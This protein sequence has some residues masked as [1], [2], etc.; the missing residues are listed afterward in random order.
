MF[1]VLI[2]LDPLEQVVALAPNVPALYELHFGV[3]MAGAVLSPLN[4][5]LDAPTLA[6]LLKQL[7]PK[8]M[9]V[10]YQFTHILFNTM[11]LIEL[12]PHLKPLL[13]IIFEP[14]QFTTE[15]NP[16]FPIDY[17]D[18]EG[19]LAIGDE[20]FDTIRP[21]NEC[22]PISICFT[23]GSTGVPKAVAYS[24]RSTYL[25]TLE[26]IFL[27]GITKPPVFL[28]VVDMF[29]C[30]GWCLTW[31]MAA[32]G[33]INIC[34]R[35]NYTASPEAI[36]HLIVTHGVSHLCGNTHLLNQI[37]A[38]D[39]P[40]QLPN[41]VDLIFCGTI[42]ANCVIKKVKNM[43]FNVKI[44]Y[45][46]TEVL[47][48]AII[49]PWKEE[50]D[51]EH[52]S[53]N[54]ILLG[55]EG[56]H[57]LMLEG[58]DVK[59]PNTMESVPN[60]G[61]T[62]GEVMFKGNTLMIGYFQNPE[63]TKEAFINGWYRTGDIAVRHLSG[64]I[65]LKDRAVDVIMLSNGEFISTLE[66][67]QVLVNH[68]DVVEAAMVGGIDDKSGQQVPYAFVD[69]KEGCCVTDAEIMKFCMDRLPSHMLPKS[70]VFGELPKNST[71]KVQKF[72]LRERAK[73]TKN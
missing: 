32:V 11:E 31:A 64:R 49:H 53:S 65:H 42:P 27:C 30:N 48:P 19:F 3:P 60:D 61:S 29:R 45:G 8:V 40:K 18:Y 25:K 47:G 17:L 67:E 7:E 70:I 38:I 36:F 68:P 41:T 73:H 56:V 44:G 6:V 52:A 4:V 54:S 5:T 57:N 22:D 1:S 66:V 33:G 12:E 24:H 55:L 58:V 23:S 43:G 50:S 10:D 34:L 69:V 63:R 20:N 37:G 46:M 51:D 13:V 28:W 2:I 21:H 59:D 16:Q 62:V 14:T 9:F 15:L 71:G 72:V 26:M 39:E 35:E